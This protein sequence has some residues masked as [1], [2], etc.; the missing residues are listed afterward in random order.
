M[1][2][3]RIARLLFAPFEKIPFNQ[4]S[5]D[6]ALGQVVRIIIVQNLNLLIR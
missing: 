1:A 2:E 5:E 4:Y 3:S 6:S